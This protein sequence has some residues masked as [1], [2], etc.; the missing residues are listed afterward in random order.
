MAQVSD[1]FSC[2]NLLLASLPAAERE[3]LLLLLERVAL[4]LRAP[5]FEPNVQPRSVHFMTT[6]IASIV[7]EMSVGEGV[8]VGLIGR[9]GLP[10]CLQL[11]GPQ[12]GPSRCF[13]QMEGEAL[14]MS[15]REFQKIF[16]ENAAV[17]APLLRYVQY[18]ALVV[19]QLA[20]C[21]RLHG[22]EERLARWLLMVADRAGRPEMELT[23]EFLAE[24]LGTRR[25]TVS[26]TAGALQQSGLILYRRGRMQILD[27]EK[28][29]TVACECLG[30]TEQLLKD[31]YP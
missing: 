16:E 4:P 5:L 7:T 14:R 2:E 9:E 13:I 22:M 30:V 6:G 31:L 12:T 29:E 23:Q 25:S 27:R 26:L 11:L 3:R 28:L 15:F 18:Q 17:R 10:E 20:A 24:M 21:N 8:E 19:A 1:Q